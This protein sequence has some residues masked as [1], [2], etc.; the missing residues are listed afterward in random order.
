M[1]T[2]TPNLKLRLSDDLTSDAR[3]NLNRIDS[4]ASVFLTDSSGTSVIRS[5][6]SIQLQPN[7]ADIGGSG[8][9]GTVS[10]GSS[11]YPI[12][13]LDIYADVI[14]FNNGQ[15]DNFSFGNLVSVILDA[16]STF[17]TTLQADQST[18]AASLVFT[19]PASAG[20]AGQ[21]LITDG[22]GNLSFSSVI[23]ETLNDNSIEV[24]N[25]SNE[26]TPIDTAAAGDILADSSSGLTIKAGTVSNSEINDSA[27]IA[28]S[29][30]ALL[31]TDRALVSSGTGIISASLVTATEL[32]YL[33][34]TTSNLQDQLDN[35]TE[36][37]QDAVGGILTDTASIDF[38]YDDGTPSITAVVL[39]AGVDHNSL[40]N[41]V[42]NEH[43]DHTSVDI[44][45][46]ANSGLAGGGDI[47][48]TRSL[49][50]DA[51]NLI[52]TTSFDDADSIII[53]DDSASDT[54]RITRANFLPGKFTADYITGD[55]TSKAVAHNLGTR[56]VLVQL[57]DT[58]TYETVYADSVV[59]TDTNTV[60][61]SLSQA[62]TNTIKVL[63]LE[64]G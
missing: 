18:Q 16:N 15:I 61:I 36:V 25:G 49:V 43:I 44:T 9:G 28:Y 35:I 24:G 39:P 41:Y 60:T 48:S 32:N 17:T 46:A 27:S 3:F 31:T 63:I 45:T 51:S 20:S 47:T 12:T 56:D 38:T 10:V 2:L 53:Y 29:K 23:T 62:P 11:V 19:L 21:T 58:V 14:D 40:N 37:A 59:R 34:G 26:R 54:T 7:S 42:A 4:L 8:V 30:L 52:E 64:V 33:S 22:S 50:I 5:Q 57:Y 55:G 6:S 1:A 13:T